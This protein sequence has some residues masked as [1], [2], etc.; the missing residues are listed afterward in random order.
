MR[1]FPDL[2][3]NRMDALK[4]AMKL[5]PEVIYLLT[6]VDQELSAPDLDQI[7]RA[8]KGRAR[9]HTIEFGRGPQ[10]DSGALNFLQKL[11]RQNGGTY[12]YYNVRQLER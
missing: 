8:N 12:R 5:G 6:D 7:Q 1:C 9:I 2:G 10:L 3:T 4:L 11:A